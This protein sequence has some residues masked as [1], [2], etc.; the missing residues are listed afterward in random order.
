MTKK[1]FQRNRPLNDYKASGLLLSHLPKEL[2]DPS[3][4][5]LSNGMGPTQERTG[6]W[7][8]PRGQFLKGID[9]Y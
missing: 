3:W 2:E 1:I 8:S 4:P 7:T 9:T 6:R 5:S